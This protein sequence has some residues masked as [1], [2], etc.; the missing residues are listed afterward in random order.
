MTLADKARTALRAIKRF[1]RPSEPA[2]LYN[3]GRPTRAAVK[4]EQAARKIGRNAEH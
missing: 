2:S 3:E 4:A 1:L